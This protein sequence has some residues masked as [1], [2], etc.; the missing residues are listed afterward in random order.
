MPDK[1]PPTDFD[2]IVIGG[3]SGGYAAAR[4]AHS[5]GMSVAVVDGAAELGGLCILKGCMP[6]K[7]LIESA[8]RNLTV[9][10]A[11]E[12]GLSAISG[13]ADIEFIRNRKRAL[14]AEFAGYR[15]GQLEDGRFTL[16]R[17]RANFISSHEIEI[18]P[19]DGSASFRLSAKTFCI[20]TGSISNVPPIPG[21]TEVGFWTS[22]DVLDAAT[23]PRSV[24]VLGGGAIALE[25]AHYLEGVGCEVTLIQRNHQFLTGVDPECSEVIEKAYTER[26]IRCYL[27][28]KLNR[29]IQDGQQK[30]IEFHWQEGAHSITVGQI[31]VAM[32]R[33][34]ATAGLELHNAH[35]GLAGRKIVTR[36]TLQTSQSHIFAAGDVCSPLDVVHVAIQQGEIA[37]RN[38]HRWVRGEPVDE[39]IDYRSLLFGVFSHPQIA[40]VGA[41]ETQLRERGIPFLS[42]K[43]PFNDHG[44]SLCMGETD[45]FVKMLAHSTSGEIL[46]ATVVGPHATE[47]IHEVVV[48]MQ[49]KCTAEQFMSIPHYHP[50]LSEIWTYPAEE[51]AD[52]IR[53]SD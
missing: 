52:A 26:G 51:L 46:G 49:F 31:L 48:A 6:S 24:V 50:T 12:F 41:S 15:Q 43:Y 5:L 18:I 9:R 37:A 13:P 42:A 33:S 2:F 19:I 20:A 21:L 53:G 7:T 38:A 3:G 29:V 8:D 16:Y 30:R 27:N 45:G 23:L 22:D 25:M 17:G 47:L 40:V 34:P 39:Q 4:T 10:R 1:I 36:P 11:A 32:G 44:K 28:T 14:I 35:V